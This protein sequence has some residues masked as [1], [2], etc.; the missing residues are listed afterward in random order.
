[1]ILVFY[2]KKKKYTVESFKGIILILTSK[3][4]LFQMYCK[5]VLA[6]I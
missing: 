5:I 1:M 6:F 4:K 3:Y 2:N